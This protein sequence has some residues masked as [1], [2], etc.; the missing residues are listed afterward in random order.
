MKLL[1]D[2]TLEQLIAEQQTAMYKLIEAQA[3]HKAVMQE[4]SNA[5]CDLIEVEAKL[6]ELKWKTFAQC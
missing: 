4:I 5:R 6:R 1:Q 3:K 2:E